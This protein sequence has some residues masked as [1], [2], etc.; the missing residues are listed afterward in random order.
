MEVGRIGHYTVVDVVVVVVVVVVGGGV[1]GAEA[2][3]SRSSVKEEEGTCS[4]LDH[5]G[6]D[7]LVGC[8]FV[9][10]RAEVYHNFG[11]GWVGTR[12]RRR[13]VSVPLETCQ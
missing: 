7:G 4:R 9:E 2:G 10:G 8:N 11:P 6:E 13:R 5:L 12:R 1:V 3:C